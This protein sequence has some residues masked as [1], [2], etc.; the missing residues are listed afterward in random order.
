MSRLVRV[1][2]A[3]S[4][5]ALAAAPVRAV[6]DL[7]TSALPDSRLEILVVEIDN[8]IY[9]GL[10]RRDVAPTYKVSGR[11]KTIPMRF[12]D[13]N[14]PDVDRL[15]LTAPIDSVPTVLVVE[16]GREL[17]RIAG[18]VGPEN[19]FHSLNRL[20]PDSSP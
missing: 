1:V 5:C 6:V 11:A 4:L 20:L 19:F 12:I 9:C 2:V 13:I 14:A 8:C 10:F 17:G 15:A 7:E 18:Y 16:N 3:L